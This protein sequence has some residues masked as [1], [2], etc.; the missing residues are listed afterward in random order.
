MFKP[1]FNSYYQYFYIHLY[2]FKLKLL[3]VASILSVSTHCPVWCY[4]YCALFYNTT[5]MKFTLL[6]ITLLSIRTFNQADLFAK[7]KCGN[8]ALM[9]YSLLTSDTFT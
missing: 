8:F 5:V 6:L 4:I 2:V 7:H 3:V 1:N 9:T